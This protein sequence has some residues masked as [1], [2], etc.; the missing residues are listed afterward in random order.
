M[1]AASSATRPSAQPGPWPTHYTCPYT[2]IPCALW[3]RELCELLGHPSST[4]SW[5]P[6]P[7]PNEA[8]PWDARVERW[9]TGPSPCCQAEQCSLSPVWATPIGVAGVRSTQGLSPPS[10]CFFM[11]KVANPMAASRVAGDLSGEK[12]SAKGTLRW[13]FKHH[14]TPRATEDESLHLTWGPHSCSSGI[15]ET[16]G[17]SSTGS[18]PR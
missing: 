17:P 9:V 5:T 18:L 11:S 14:N 1:Q 15:G 12:P 8:W 2:G 4:P 7:Y 16:V 3:R 6:I 10:T 13:P